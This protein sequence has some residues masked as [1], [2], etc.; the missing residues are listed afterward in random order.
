MSPL[1]YGPPSDR[2]APELAPSPKRYSACT[3]VG[4]IR[5]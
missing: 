4:L 1:G 3:N 2:V 5:T